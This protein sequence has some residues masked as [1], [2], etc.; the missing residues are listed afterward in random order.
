M[1][2]ITHSLRRLFMAFLASILLGSAAQ[3][4]SAVVETDCAAE[5]AA[6]CSNVLPGAGR[7]V[8]CLIAHENKISPRC[9]M[10][11]YLASGDLDERLKVL[12]AAAKVCSADIL[13]YCSKV[14]AGGGRIF[15]CLKSNKATLTNDCRNLVPQ[16]EK[17]MSD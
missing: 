10:S 1:Q 4:Q 6:H 11:A 15:D 14:P 17:V 2:T 12:R 5:I 7:I 13:Q 8:A 16:F 3:A 9:R